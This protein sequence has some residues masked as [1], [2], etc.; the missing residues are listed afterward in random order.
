MDLIHDI[1]NHFSHFI[2]LETKEGPN[3]LNSSST[4]CLS[5]KPGNCDHHLLPHPYIQ[6]IKHIL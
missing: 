5:Q 3:C 1:I 2:N 6:F 4:S